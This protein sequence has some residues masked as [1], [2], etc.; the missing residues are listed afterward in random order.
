[1]VS[2]APGVTRKWKSLADYSNEVARARIYAGFHYCFSTEAAQAMGKK[3]GELMVTTQL[4]H[5]APAKT[6][7]Q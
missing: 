1:L 6:A 5:L 4:V 2:L 7:K 3:I